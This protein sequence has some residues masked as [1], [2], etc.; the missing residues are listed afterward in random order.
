MQWDKHYIGGGWRGGEG[1]GN[2]EQLKQICS[3]LPVMAQ[4]PGKDER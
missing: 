1:A 2:T 3:Q 4:E